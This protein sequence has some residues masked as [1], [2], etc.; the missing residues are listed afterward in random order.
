MKLTTV[1]NVSVD[2]VMQGLGGPDEDRRGGF[3]RG[4]W[5]PPLFVDEAAMF[6]NGV[7]QR[8]DAFLFG[9]RTYEIFAGYWGVMPDPDDNPIAGPLN[10]RPKY[11]ASTTLSDPQWADTTVLSGDVAAAV[12]ELKAKPAG[13]LQVHGS[14]ALIRWLL[15]HELVDEIILL[16]VPVVLGQGTR[17]FPDAGPDIALDLVDSRADSKGV[18][19]QVYRPTGRPQY[20]PASAD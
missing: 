9:R 13:E 12:G 7:F 19:I 15:E 11:V 16:I 14:G 1:T 3:E 10:S 6:L 5:A 18:T 4:G 8:A 20:A 17:L 2:G